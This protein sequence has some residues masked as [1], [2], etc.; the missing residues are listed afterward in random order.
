MSRA[1]ARKMITLD[2]HR[3]AM[4]GIESRI[5]MDILDESPAAYKPLGAV[6]EA[7]DDLVEIVHRLKPL[8][9]VKG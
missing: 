4:Q 6:M 1:K 3:E 7:Q 5:D 8:I 9:N 2:Q